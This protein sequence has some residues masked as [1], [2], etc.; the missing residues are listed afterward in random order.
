MHCPTSYLVVFCDNIT[1]EVSLFREGAWVLVK[2]GLPKSNS[3]FFGACWKILLSFFSTNSEDVIDYLCLW[4]LCTRKRGLF[5]VKVIRIANRWFNRWWICC[6]HVLS[7]LLGLE[8][9]FWGGCPEKKIDIIEWIA[10]SPFADTRFAV[11]SKV[12]YLRLCPEGEALTSAMLNFSISLPLS[13]NGQWFTL[14]IRMD[15]WA[16]NYEFLSMRLLSFV[17]VLHGNHQ[18]SCNW[19]FLTK[20]HH[21]WRIL[22]SNHPY[23]KLE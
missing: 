6:R 12:T 19:D 7:F 4:S 10:K 18:F 11:Q 5:K 9:E 13:C 22:Q 21:T 3:F 20:H 8:F 1:G 2:E 16:C 14:Y 15:T 23:C 17:A